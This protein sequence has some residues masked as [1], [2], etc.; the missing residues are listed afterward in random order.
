[1]LDERAS[2]QSAHAWYLPQQSLLC[3]Q[4]FW[5]R[6]TR[7]REAYIDACP[8]WDTWHRARLSV[9]LRRIFEV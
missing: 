8:Q 2:L 3:P 4:P 5:V 6:L 9:F 1:L 7:R